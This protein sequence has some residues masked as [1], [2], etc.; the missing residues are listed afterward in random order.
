MLK[1]KKL[2]REVVEQKMQQRQR[3]MQTIYSVLKSI[4]RQSMPS[5]KEYLPRIF[6]INQIR[7]IFNEMRGPNN[8]K[9]INYTKLVALAHLCGR[10][11][12]EREAII[13][14][15]DVTCKNSANI[16]FEEFMEALEKISADVSS[17]PVEVSKVVIKSLTN[18][19]SS[20]VSLKNLKNSLEMTDGL[21][22]ENDITS[23]IEEVKYLPS[24]HAQHSVS[25]IATLI[26][27]SIEG[28]PR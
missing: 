12:N 5:S 27:D 18:T 20:T 23:L 3:T 14:A 21:F 25:I 13:L 9:A 1:D 16:I 8:D 17:N 2:V 10:D 19:S 6:I 28:M 26:R 15:H 4:K 22:D 11:L 24:E 7:E